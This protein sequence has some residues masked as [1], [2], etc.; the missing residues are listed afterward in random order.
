M[1]RTQLCPDIDLTRDL[2]SLEINNGTDSS[3]ADTAI[4]ALPMNSLARD[5]ID[6]VAILSDRTRDRDTVTQHHPLVINPGVDIPTP[7]RPIDETSFSP[8]NDPPEHELVPSDDENVLVRL[9]DT[10]IVPAPLAL[11]IGAKPHPDFQTVTKM[12]FDR[13]V[14]TP[15][16]SCAPPGTPN[17]LDQTAKLMRTTF[18]GKS[19]SIG[20]LQDAM[21]LKFGES[22]WVMFQEQS[23]A[24]RRPEFWEIPK[25]SIDFQYIRTKY[26]AQNDPLP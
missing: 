7:A 18:L 20:L 1:S 6:A 24:W 19:S 4:D 15:V 26:E 9:T 11:A 2:D 13:P 23:S 14:I 21:E 17:M 22:G 3:F 5:A 10:E 12:G 8:A 25:V 16:S